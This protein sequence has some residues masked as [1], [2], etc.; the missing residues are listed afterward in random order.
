LEIAV[1]AARPAGK[2]SSTIKT[3]TSK[4]KRKKK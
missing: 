2:R 3:K 4:N 1:A